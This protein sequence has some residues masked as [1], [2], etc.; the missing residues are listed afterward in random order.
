MRLRS[1][2]AG[3]KYLFPAD[4]AKRIFILSQLEKSVNEEW[5]LYLKYEKM[6]GLSEKELPAG[7][8]RFWMAFL[9]YGF[10]F[11]IDKVGIQLCG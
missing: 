7:R 8:S 4:S 5:D 10:Q 6:I 3:T 1:V 9:I 11:L 2:A